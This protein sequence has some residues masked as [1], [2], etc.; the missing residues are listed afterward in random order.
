MKR[1]IT[2][3]SL[4]AV[5]VANVDAQPVGEPSLSKL[6]SV[7]AKLRGF[8]DDNYNTA[9]D[10]APAGVAYDKG[11]SFGFS[12]A[13][14]IGLNL[15][16]DQT[17]LNLR[18]DFDLRWYEARDDDQ[19]DMYHGASLN[20]DHRFSER[21][22]VEV[23]DQFN[24]SDEPS[25]LESNGQQ[26]TFYRSE[27]DNLRNYGGI[28]FYGSFTENWGYRLGFENTLY[29][30]SEEGAGSR[31]ALLDR[32]ENK[33]TID[34]RRVLQP[35]TVALVGYS[36]TDV[37]YTA[38]EF[39]SFYDQ[40]PGDATSDFRNSRNHFG[41]VGLDHA[42]TARLDAK[43]R[44]GAQFADYYN[45]GDDQ[46]SPYADVMFGYTYAEGSRVQLG[47]KTGMIATD[48]AMSATGQGVT[49]G[50]D[51]TTTF[52]GVNHRLT[53]R[54][55]AQ[56]R[57]MWQAMSY[58]GDSPYSDEWDNYYTVDVGLTYTLNTY[59]ALEAGYLWDRLDSD[60]SNRSFS[61]N[62]GYF[63]VRATY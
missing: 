36:Y 15:I 23:Y 16:G 3:A 63:G 44:L 4:V 35:N 13:P 48:V 28:G 52:V 58:F 12:L 60:I 6:W 2:C 50:A 51:S 19:I 40:D 8:Y 54:L 20:F 57:G 31:S 39:L 56:A 53:S 17:T 7:S 27:D 59:V 61:R 49:L 62:R 32:M 55:N 18:Y 42:F 30:Y 46:I 5:G 37:D 11:E 24:Y 10:S 21:Y 1:L 34:F 38:D 25:V 9:P 45:A 26:T 14:S 29:D 41:F 22:R 47:V 43:V 33:P